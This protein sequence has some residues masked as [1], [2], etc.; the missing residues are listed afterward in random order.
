MISCHMCMKWIHM[1][2]SN[3]NECELKASVSW[4]CTECRRLPGL[5]F[6][7]VQQLRAS[8]NRL[9][10]IIENYTQERNDFKK[11][12]ILMKESSE[13]EIK[14]LK[15][16]NLD[17][18]STNKSL[19]EELQ[20]TQQELRIANQTSTKKRDL[21]KNTSSG[22][23]DNLI[24]GSSIIKHIDPK[25]AMNTDVISISGAKCGDICNKLA[26]MGR[27]CKNITLVVG[28][29]DCSS[30]METIGIIENFALLVACAKSCASESVSVTGICPRPENPI[31]QDRINQVNIA[32]KTASEKHDFKFIDTNNMFTL[33]DG[34]IN[35]GYLLDDGVHLTY[36]GTE[37]L[38]QKLHVLNYKEAVIRQPKPK[39][40]SQR[41]GK[42]STPSHSSRYGNKS[43]FD[44]Y[45]SHTRPSTK[46]GTNNQSRCW[47]CGESGH[48]INSCKHSS[49]LRCFTCN[50]FGHKSK[51]CVFKLD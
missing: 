23:N 48:V 11:Q 8:N 4:C 14:E 27:T 41:V 49:R 12:M 1:L 25:A 29:N 34:S 2:C 40:Y 33:K 36:K 22:V 37:K 43:S 39:S 17:L 47:N 44:S 7:Q 24:I 51:F 21:I 3:D 20:N 28:G 30:S 32:L 10:K 31:V 50:K 26:S 18:V 38:A 42:G 19:S 16:I 9:L 6:S 15:K 35:D 45:I 5:M 46:S 13:S